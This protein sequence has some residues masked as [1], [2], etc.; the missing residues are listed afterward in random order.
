MILLSNEIAEE[1]SQQLGGVWPG[2]EW[3]TQLY[4]CLDGKES[5]YKTGQ[6]VAIYN[7]WPGPNPTYWEFVCTKGQFDKAVK[8]RAAKD[9]V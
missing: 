1:V 2:E 9:H 8:D 7:S 5:Q 4:R 3:E 6:L